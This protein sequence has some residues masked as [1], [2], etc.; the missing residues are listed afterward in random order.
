[1]VTTL[2]QARTER[3]QLNTYARR[4]AKQQREA[5]CADPEYGDRLKKFCATLNHYKR[6]DQAQD[7]T[8]WVTKQCRQWLRAAPADIRYE[9][10]SACHEQT[11]RI[12][13][14]AGLAPLEDSLPGEP[15]SVF[16]ICKKAM[17]L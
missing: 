15:P 13:M 11:Q 2:D 4:A 10:L 17:G 12:R 16:E 1:M 6:L 9:A 14:R 5:L 8:D 7:F 3:D